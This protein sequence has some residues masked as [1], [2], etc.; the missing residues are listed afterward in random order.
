M[1][2]VARSMSIDDMIAVTA[3]AA[4][5]APQADASEVSR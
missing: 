5:L 4:S 1:A 2:G 3:Y